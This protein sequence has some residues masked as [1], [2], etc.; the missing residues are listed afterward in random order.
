MPQVLD[1]VKCNLTHHVSE[2]RIQVSCGRTYF[3]VLSRAPKESHHLEA[4]SISPKM[5]RANN[6]MG[7]IATRV[8]ESCLY[9]FHSCKTS[10][11]TLPPESLGFASISF[12]LPSHNFSQN[13]I[14]E[15]DL[16]SFGPVSRLMLRSDAN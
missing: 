11:L 5:V 6:V 15:A 2:Y 9:I 12:L 14:P 7:C 4:K 8:P 16:L 10:L 13:E 3:P 1:L